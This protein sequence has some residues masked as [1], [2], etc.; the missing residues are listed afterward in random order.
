MKED[1][2]KAMQRK[3]EQ[4]GKGAETLVEKTR[5]WQVIKQFACNRLGEF[6][7]TAEQQKKFKRYQ[8]IYDQLVSGRYTEQEVISQLINIHKIKLTQ[9]YEDM[10]AAKEVFS[11]AVNVKKQFELQ[12]ELQTARR[13]RLK[14]EDMGDMK[15]AAMYSKVITEIIKQLPEVE[16]VPAEMF[17]GH[18]IEADFDPSLLGAPPVNMRAVLAAINEKRDKKIKIDMFEELPFEEG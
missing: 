14:C 16:D 10:N 3:A 1:V 7:L 9:A 4:I 13:A 15:T 2:Y 17:E 12:V 18:I 11:L 6:I 8:L 5:D